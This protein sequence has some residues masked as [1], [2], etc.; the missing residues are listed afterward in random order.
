MKICYLGPERPGFEWYL[1]QW[2]DTVERQDGPFIDRDYDRLVSWGYRHIL[3]P[4]VVSAY[5]GRAVNLHISYLPWNRGADPNF[6]SWYDHTPKGVT[7]HYID[8]GID[9][10]EIITQYRVWF[11]GDPTL[12]T[13]YNEL[14]QAMF[15]TF[16]AVWPFLRATKDFW[17][18]GYPKGKGTFHT[19]SE[20]MAIQKH[21]KALRYWGWDIPVGYIEQMK[22]AAYE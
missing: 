6:W 22:E 12:A 18:A 13:S 5:K 2:G 20:L 21:D 3:S 15:R 8:E 19:A 16:S 11:T 9:T 4:D 1:Q 10:G 7:V 17:L 14:Q